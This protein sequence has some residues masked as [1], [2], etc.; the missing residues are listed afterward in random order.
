MDRKLYYYLSNP[1]R[2]STYTFDSNIEK[3]NK[4]LSSIKNEIN[5]YKYPTT[6]CGKEEGIETKNLTSYLASG[7]TFFMEDKDGKIIGVINFD[8]NEKKINIMGVCTP[9]VGGKI[10][11]KLIL[12]VIDFAKQ[13]NMKNIHLTCLTEKLRNYYKNIGFRE[14][15]SSIKSNDSE[16]E[17]VYNMNME[18]RQS[19]SKSRSKKSNGGK[20]TKRKPYSRIRHIL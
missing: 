12:N 9:I 4:T 19:N 16:Y 6:F 13:N 8:I 3:T 15:V 7:I 17:S 2:Y 5:E 18:I 10:G 20:K 1:I 11:N 14:L